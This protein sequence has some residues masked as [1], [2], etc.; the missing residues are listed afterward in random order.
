MQTQRKSGLRSG[1]TMWMTTA[2]LVLAL[3]AGAA[4]ASPSNKWRIQVSSDSDTDGV[5]V[6]HLAPVGEPAVD[7]TVPVPKGAGE[8]HVADL[9]RDAMRAR[10]GDG[11][12]IEVDDGE[13]VLV[14]KHLGAKNFDL[15][16]KQQTVK[17][18]RITL[19]KE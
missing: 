5:V 10:L 6:F 16:I 18:V 3:S 11:Y 8:N 17:G 19:D 12:R 14:K 1:S 7:V 13:D 15:T 2:A 4:F 9:I